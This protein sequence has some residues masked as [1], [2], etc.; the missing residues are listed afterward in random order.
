MGALQ[1]YLIPV[2]TF[3]MFL[4]GFGGCSLFFFFFKAAKVIYIYTDYCKLQ[5]TH[6]TPPHP[7]AQVFLR[8][9]TFKPGIFFF[10]FNQMKYI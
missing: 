6:P 3:S 7:P 8:F 2:L 5:S 10:F 9:R 4:V 1:G